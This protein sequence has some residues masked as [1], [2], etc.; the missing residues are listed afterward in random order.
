MLSPGE[1][2]LNPHAAKAIGHKALDA[3]NASAKPGGGQHAVRANIQTLAGGGIPTGRAPVPGDEKI[4]MDAERF[5]GHRYV[6]GGASNPTNGWDCSS[7]VGY[8]LGHDFGMRLPG[9]VKWNPNVHGPVASD[10]NRTPGFQ[11]A[12]H[13]T[14]DILAGDLLVENSGG[15]VGF[16][17]G[18]NTMFSAYDT[19]LGTLQTTAANMTNIYRYTGNVSYNGPLSA[20]GNVLKSLASLA[21]TGIENLATAGLSHVPGTGPLHDLPIAVVRKLIDA[22]KAKLTGNPNNYQ[23]TGGGPGGVPGGNPAGGATG[24]RLAN[25]TE[26]YL[27]LLKN[28]FGG[29][30]IAAAGAVASIDGESAWNPFAQGTGGRG[31]IGWTPPGTI[32]NAD[33]SGGMRTQ[34]PAVLRFVVNSGDSGVIA[35]MF[36]ASSIN[37]A[38]QEW[39]HG[40]ERAGINDVHS[41][42]LAMASQIMR[43]HASGGIIK[44]PV[45]GV[46]MK[47][48]LGYSFGEGGRNERVL[49]DAQ[50]QAY[51][52]RFTAQ[53]NNGQ[54][55]QVSLELPSTGNDFDKFLVEWLRG[56]VRV[57]GGGDVQRAFGRR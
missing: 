9:G 7:F 35:Q 46:G 54:P 11:L 51:D 57:K 48:G 32:S 44:E 12:S 56:K 49:T 1:Y 39:D 40:V 8:I 31:L 55:I 15:H 2:V 19:A 34:L 22:A 38:A 16:G 42:G 18:P 37:E 28:L 10:Y 36:R 52:H 41:A 4:V 14:A 23:P 17:V 21:L 29:N 5:K 25:A 6:W 47:S 33:F 53:G 50:T 45:I 26:G 30:K 43:S 27:Y 24:S 20:L 3:I 13:N